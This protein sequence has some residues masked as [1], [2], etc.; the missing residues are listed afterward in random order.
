MALFSVFVDATDSIAETSE[1]NNEGS[2]TVPIV[3]EEEDDGVI[4]SIG[5]G[6]AMF[7]LAVGLVLI[8][9][10]ALYFG[11]GRVSRPFERR[12]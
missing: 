1:E 9:L 12:K 4:D 3:G 5:R 7:F 8:S 11:P 10:T 6:P 2:V